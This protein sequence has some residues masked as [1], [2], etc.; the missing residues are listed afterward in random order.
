MANWYGLTRSNYVGVKDPDKFKEWMS[1][2]ADL[3]LITKMTKDSKTLYGFHD[4]S[5]EG[6]IPSYYEDVD[7][8]EVDVDFLAEFAKHLNEDQVLIIMQAGHEKARYASGYS[9]AVN[10]KGQTIQLD[11]DDIYDKARRLFGITPTLA[12][13]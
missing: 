4:I 7:G 2:F 11:L 3:Q 8:N 13:Y 12:T 9:I 6:G 5:G 10:H 1:N